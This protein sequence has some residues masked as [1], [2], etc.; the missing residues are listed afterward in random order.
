M[1]PPDP[2]ANTEPDPFSGAEPATAGAVSVMREVAAVAHL[3]LLHR[4]VAAR[5]AGGEK[6]LAVFAISMICAWIALDWSLSTDDLVFAPYALPGL[7][8]YALGFVALAWLLWRLSMPTVA[9]RRVLLVTIGCAPVAIVAALVDDYLER[10]W[11][12]FANVLLACWGILY[13]RNALRLISGA[14][15]RR[16]L[17][18][19]AVA[20]LVFVAASRAVTVS[21]TVWDYAEQTAGDESQDETEQDTDEVRARVAALQFGQQARVDAELATVARHASA[22]PEVFFLGFAGNG[23]QRVFAEEIALAAKVVGARYD[24]GDREL[25]LVNDSRDLVR[26]PFATPEAL[27]HALHGLGAMMDPEDV[28]FLSISSHGGED[29]SIEIANAGMAS[30]ELGVDDLADMLKS[31]KIPRA[32]IVVS[33][34]YAGAFVPVLAD[35]NTTVITA[36]AADR[37]SFG[38]ADDRDLTYFGEAFYRDA[39]PGAPTLRDA[40]ETA[41]RAIAERERKE[42]VE[43]SLPQ[44]RIGTLVEQRLAR[45]GAG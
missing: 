5:L 1:L 16:A 37:T 40:F 39:L 18:A 9:F 41:R 11:L 28:L 2:P 30:F 36:A 10:G 42:H 15:Q 38:C 6:P 26:W 43:P 24:A 3:W 7:A 23:R 17:A 12:Y 45:D 22:R 44:A 27:R 4:P 34:C 20:V 13:F 25:R 35:E 19:G 33:A 29:G 32:V 8:W 14:P 21:A 31:A